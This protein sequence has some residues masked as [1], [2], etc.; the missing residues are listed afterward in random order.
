MGTQLAAENIPKMFENLGSPKN[1][2]IST[3]MS[4]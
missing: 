2:N 1:V 3:N 4:S